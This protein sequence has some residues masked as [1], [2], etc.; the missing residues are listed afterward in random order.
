M[1]G[2]QLYL[3]ESRNNEYNWKYNKAWFCDTVFENWY[4]CSAIGDHP[5]SYIVILYNQ[6]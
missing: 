1:I 6:L 3:F 5:A 4:D 2:I